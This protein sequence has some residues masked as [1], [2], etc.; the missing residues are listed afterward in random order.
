MSLNVYQSP[1][2]LLVDAVCPLG[3]SSV[4]PPVPSPGVSDSLSRVFNSFLFFYPSVRYHSSFVMLVCLAGLG[5]V[6]FQAN[7]AGV[8]V[9]SVGPGSSVLS[10]S[11]I[12]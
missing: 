2:Q 9:F 3:A 4:C 1:P 12:S 8:E 7:V 11:P 10:L 6:I 5:W